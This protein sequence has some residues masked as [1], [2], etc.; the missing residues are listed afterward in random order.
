MP[1]TQ[2]KDKVSEI[3]TQAQ[4]SL[5]FIVTS[6][7][8]LKTVDINEFR[9]KIRPFKAEY[10][11]VKN[12]LTKIA[13]KNAGYEALGNMLSGPSAVVIE[14]GDTVGTLKAI[15]EFAKTHEALKVMGGC[16]EGK[17]LTG[18]ELKT[19]SSLPSREVLIS[20]LLGVLQGP[21]TNLVNVLQATTRNLVNVLDAVAKKSEQKA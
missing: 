13:L 8:G 19:L 1:T 4:Q 2:K 3:Q 5:G 6:Y 9:L 16:L 21:A 18:K 7:G 12:S 17:V 15:F 11:V 20:Q 10:R 14:R